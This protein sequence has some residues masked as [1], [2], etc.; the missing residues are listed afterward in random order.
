MTLNEAIAKHAL[1]IDGSISEAKADAENIIRKQMEKEGCC[2]EFAEATFIEDIEDLDLGEIEEYTKNAKKVAKLY[3]KAEPK[4]TKVKRVREHKEN[5]DKLEIIQTL[6]DA[7]CDLVD[8]VVVSNK[9][10]SI[11]F[12]YNGVEYSVTLTAHRKPKAKA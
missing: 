8:N 2:R 7:L 12:E 1:A 11:D 5:P 3:A 10:R 4:E 6:D 9:E